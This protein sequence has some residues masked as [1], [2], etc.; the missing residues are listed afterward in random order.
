MSIP[1]GRLTPYPEPR[2][3]ADIGATF[4][5]FCIEEVPG[6]FDHVTVLPCDEYPGFVEVVQAYLAR[7]PGVRPRHGAMAIA[8]PIEGD[9]IRMTNRAWQ[10]SIREAQAALKLNTLLVVNNFTALAMALPRLGPHERRQI[11]GGEPQANGVIGLLGPGTGLGVSGLIPHD[12]RWITLASEGGHASFGPSD[13]REL[14]VLQHVWK[15]YPRVSIERLVSGP[16]LELI[17]EAL[18]EGAP[19]AEPRLPAAEIVRR[20]LHGLNDACVDTVGCFCGMLGTVASDLALTLGATGGIYVGGGIVPR[21][22]DFFAQSSFRERFEAKGRL[23]TYVARIPTYVVT[24]EHPAFYGVST[25]LDEHMP[26]REGGNPLLERLRAA[27]T[28]LSPAER[29]VADYVLDNPRAVL[30]EPV[31]TI[32]QLAE[33]SQPTVI[34]FCR[35]LG[36]Q[37]LADFKLKLGAG[38]TGTLPVQRSQVRRQDATADL[39]AKVLDNT[40]SAIVQFRETLNVEAVD[41]AISLLREAKRVEFYALGNSAIVALDAQHKLFR[42]RIPSVAHTDASTLA[43]AAELLG[44]QDVAVF[45]S[46]SGQP[47]ELVRAA[48]L[49]QERGAGVIAITAGQSPLGKRAGVSIAVEHGEDSSTFVSMLSRILHLLVVD[50]VSV[51][52][53]VRRTPDGLPPA[54]GGKDAEG[55]TLSAPGV[56]ISHIA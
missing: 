51:G 48:T 13:E 21:L 44:P 42:F 14:R 22:G 35:S 5:R 37:G 4:A 16:G 49:A 19:A 53:A 23:S 36:F 28:S 1:A 25:L 29:R 11:G 6:R 27:R 40:V 15:T 31:A 56:F 10:F 8:N 34:R 2:L 46:S 38:L 39:C 18:A 12:D 52:L 54:A 20:A 3:L 47:P 33:V 32:A 9:Q 43:M 7:L 30:N 55:Q 50:M 24:A 26:E 41:H 17:Y 45:I